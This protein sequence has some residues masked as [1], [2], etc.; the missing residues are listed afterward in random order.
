MELLL[1]EL[2]PVSLTQKWIQTDE[3]IDKVRMKQT[4]FWL[5]QLVTD[6]N[7]NHMCDMSEPLTAQGWHRM[8]STEVAAVT[9]NRCTTFPLPART[10]ILHIY[11]KHL[12]TCADLADTF[13]FFLG[14]DRFFTVF[15]WGALPLHLMCCTTVS[16]V[17]LLTGGAGLVTATHETLTTHQQYDLIL[18]HRK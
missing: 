6:W 4:L 9:I 18:T 15:T 8:G 3:I 1:L 14:G 17:A 5:P 13:F 7:N 11:T 2:F 12:P 10:H 16:T